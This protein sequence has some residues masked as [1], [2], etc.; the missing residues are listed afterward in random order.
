IA[1]RVVV[2]FVSP[3]LAATAVSTL[4][5]HD[6]LPILTLSSASA[7]TV[8]EGGSVVYTASVNNP[9]TGADL[10]VT[11]SNGQTITIPV[12]QSTGSVTSAE[13]T[14]EAYSLADDGFSVLLAGN[15][16]AKHRH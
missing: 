9:V 7:A 8:S 14:A 4:S 2:S 10:T 11:L 13:H 6:A 15:T 5:L 1:G 12:G 3:G 16:V